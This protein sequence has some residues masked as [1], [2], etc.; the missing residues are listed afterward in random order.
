MR[1]ALLLLVAACS[2]RPAPMTANRSEPAEP[3]CLAD[4]LP[5][6]AFVVPDFACEKRLS[7]ERDCEA[8]DANGC[9]AHAIK[10]QGDG[11]DHAAIRYFGRTCQLGSSIGCTNLG[12]TR[13]ALGA[14]AGITTT[15]MSRLFDA[16]CAARD[17]WGC[18][19]KGRFLSEHAKT[20]ADRAAARAHFDR[21]CNDLGDV[22][23]RMFALHLEKKQLGTWSPQLSRALMLRACE[24]GDDLACGHDTASETFE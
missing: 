18:G 19:M 2:T 8:N 3:A 17:P 16:S 22:T 15:C 23:C 10:L 1:V 12:A 7:C 14:D 21:V 6:L 5:A 24:T 20:D 9:F 11:D 4:N 13:W